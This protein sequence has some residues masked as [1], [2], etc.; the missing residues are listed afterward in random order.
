M[1]ISRFSPAKAARWALPAA[2]ACA[3]LAL[4]DPAH[5]EDGIEFLTPLCPE[6]IPVIH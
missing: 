6:T 3:F 1:T 4:P 5:A 2:L